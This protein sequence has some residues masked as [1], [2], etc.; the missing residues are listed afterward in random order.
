MTGVS[1]AS[2]RAPRR[3]GETCRAVRA[4][5]EADAPRLADEGQLTCR[6]AFDV[7]DSVTVCLFFPF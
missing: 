7:D 2:I 3:A 6:E 4:P 1:R 5:L